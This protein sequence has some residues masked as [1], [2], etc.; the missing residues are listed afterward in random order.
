MGLGEAGHRLLYPGDQGKALR[1]PPGP[2]GAA[3]AA[4]LAA[5]A[6]Q[7][8]RAGSQRGG[9]HT[10]GAGRPHPQGLKI[11]WAGQGRRHPVRVHRA[12]AEG[13]RQGRE[14]GHPRGRDRGNQ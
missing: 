12:A 10:G 3:P 14:G 4:H 7:V 6:R 5:V 9:G 8:H 2:H 11:P 1:Q 13:G